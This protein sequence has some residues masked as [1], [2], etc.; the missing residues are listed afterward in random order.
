M[1]QIS[2]QKINSNIQKRKKLTSY[3]RD[4]IIAK[5]ELERSN[6]TIVDEYEIL[7]FTVH[8][9]LKVNSLCK[10]NKSLSQFD[11]F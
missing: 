8:N 4:Q 7:K 3:A 5:A 2:L 11:H 9:T 6:Y 1:S 10:D